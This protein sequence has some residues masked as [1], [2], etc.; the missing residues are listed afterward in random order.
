M[1]HPGIGAIELASPDPARLAAFY[2]TAFDARPDGAAIS[3]GAQTVRFRKVPA[4]TTQLAPANAT[5]FQ[6]FAI[7]V[8]DMAAAMARLAGVPGWQ[9]ISRGGPRQLPAG[10]GGVTAFKF[11]DPDGHPLE[12]LA[13]PAHQAPAPWRHASG[14]FLGI[15]HTAITVTN[16]ARSI[17]FWQRL[18][19]SRVGGSLNEGAEQAALDGLD[20]PRVEVTSLAADGAP[21][22][23]ELLCYLAPP[24]FADARLPADVL[25]TSIIMTGAGS[26]AMADPDGHRLIARIPDPDDVAKPTSPGG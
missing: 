25:A 8:A 1:S 6:H 20:A 2:H 7:V 5:S 11:R 15:D 14:L 10:A 16:P 26:S 22:H 4:V 17:A 12:L 19:F 18:G 21:P 3:L 13:F 9:P 23:L 24:A